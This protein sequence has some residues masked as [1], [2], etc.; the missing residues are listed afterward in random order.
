MKTLLLAFLITVSPLKKNDT[1]FRPRPFNVESYTSEV[2]ELY[3]NYYSTKNGNY[4][5]IRLVSD[6]IYTFTLYSQ[7]NNYECYGEVFWISINGEIIKVNYIHNWYISDTK[8]KLVI[9]F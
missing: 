6:G 4:G 5:I 2:D 1:N 8:L 7:Y 9:Y 3:C